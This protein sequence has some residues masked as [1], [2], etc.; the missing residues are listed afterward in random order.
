MNKIQ[1]MGR[2]TDDLKLR[3]TGNGKVVGRGR[4]AVRRQYKVAPGKDEADFIG[5]VVWGTKASRMAQLTHKGAMI[6]VDGS[7]TTGSF[8]NEQ[9]ERIYTTEVNVDNFTLTETKEQSETYRE[10]QKEK[11]FVQDPKWEE[12]STEPVH[13]K[14]IPIQQTMDGLEVEKSRGEYHW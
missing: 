12:E 8:I 7:L 3:E 5:I 14:V 2:L 10:S 9:G 4:I 1:L 13:E 6:G 11:T